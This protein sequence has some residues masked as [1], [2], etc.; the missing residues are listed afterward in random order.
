MKFI[1]RLLNKTKDGFVKENVVI[2]RVG[3]MDYLGSELGMGLNPNEF[4]AVHVTPDEL[5][6]KETIESVEGVDATYIHPDKLEITLN[7][8]RGLTVGHVQNIYQDGDFLKGTIFI[9]D[10]D[11]IATVEQ[12]GIKEVSLGYDSD[13]IEKDGKLVK[14]NIRA[15]HLAIV[16]EGRCGPACKIGDSKKGTQTMFKK[17]TKLSLADSIALSFGGKTS[18]QKAVARKFGD[19]R[20][21]LNDAKVKL[22]DSARQK[23]ADLE[24]VM[25]NPDATDEQKAAAVE[26]VATV[27][28]DIAKAIEILDGADTSVTEA[29]KAVE[30]IPVNDAALPE[31]VTLE[32]LEDGVKQY[33]AE[34]ESERDGAV[35]QAEDLQGQLDEAKAEI[36]SLKAELES[37][38]GAGETATAVADA[39]ARFPKIK[40]GDS[41]KSARDVQA[42][43]LIAKGVYNDAQVKTLTDCAIGSAYQTLVVR[44][45]KAAPTFGKKLV[46]E[47]GQPKNRASQ[48][49]GK[50]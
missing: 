15:N 7:D 28:D 47:K 48:L 5:F 50:K 10:K 42:Q 9:K 39:K 11:T 8:W 32:G 22:G 34:L 17:K 29:E 27:S 4:Y 12:D 35:S 45:S 31:G 6:K 14:T 41:V 13:I 1:D 38:K 25:T 44:D 30:E 33:I 21:K 3:A 20:K 18:G 24:A 26:A 36:E 23:L 43:V 2:A 37:L 19:M 16:P 40:I 46:D 49:G